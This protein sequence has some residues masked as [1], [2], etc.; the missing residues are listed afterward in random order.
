[1][2]GKARGVLESSTA[3]GPTEVARLNPNPKHSSASGLSVHA[4]EVIRQL[5]TALVHRNKSGSTSVF[6]LIAVR[7]I[8]RAAS[9]K[10]GDGFL[11]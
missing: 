6:L 9:I 7:L 1:M 2:R 10:I 5:L 11:E 3:G 4:A 8:G